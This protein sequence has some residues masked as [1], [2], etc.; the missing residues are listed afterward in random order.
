[1]GSTRVTKPFLSGG[2]LV[3]CAL[4]SLA[5][6]AC[7]PETSTA[8]EASLV[9]ETWRVIKDSYVEADTLDSQQ[10]TGSLIGSMLEAT[11]KPVYPFLTELHGVRGRP[12]AGVPTEL[13]DAWKA[14]VLFQEKWPEV[15]R[16][17]LADAAVE[18]VLDSLEDDT[19]AHLTPEL[20]ARARES[21]TGAYQ[22]IG[23][24]VDSQE[25]RMIIFP[26][27]GSPA[28]EAGLKD[29]DATL[30]VNGKSVE[31]KSVQEVVEEVR[32][33]IGTKVT[34]LIER[35]GEEQPLE[36]SVIR[37]EISRVSVQGQLLPGAIGYIYISHF[38]V[39]TP[40]D[41]LD[42][43]EELKLVDMLALILD[44]RSNP[45]GSI[46]SALKVASQFLSDGLLMYEI[47]NGGQRRDWPIEEGGIATAELPMV[48]MVNEVTSSEAEAV[49]G[50]L[51][52]SQRATILGSTTF[53]KG[54]ANSFRELS[55]GSALY[56]PVTHW[57]RPLGVPIHGIGIEPDIKVA[58]TD[59]DRIFQVDSQ[60]R[61]AYNYLDELLPEFR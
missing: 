22:G 15:D 26:M 21:S 13:T 12:P 58:L 51:Q 23:A 14:W 25:G 27:E 30:E 46:E 37:D 54:S 35:L 33:P 34:L 31:G 39:N 38:L 43:L 10:V 11:E 40:D 45:G 59:E 9:W 36:F 19:V 5:F 28:E 53:G 6:V 18:G 2:L 3:L 52:D 24:L 41:L 61:E 50:A 7:R 60:L 8:D 57:F 17:F 48:V 47:D 16:K 20:Y 44:M 32:G 4:L 55:D 29:G 56:I 42:L 1:M 49:A